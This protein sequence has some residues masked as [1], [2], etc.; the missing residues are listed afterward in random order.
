MCKDYGDGTPQAEMSDML[1]ALKVAEIKEEEDWLDNGY[2]DVVSLV[3]IVIEHEKE[4]IERLKEVANGCPMCMLAAIRQTTKY[5]LAF[6]SFNFNLEKAKFWQSAND[7]GLIL[8][9][10]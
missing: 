3:N 1:E 7:V 6:G 10:G 5:P 9:R 4:A 8:Y 2:G